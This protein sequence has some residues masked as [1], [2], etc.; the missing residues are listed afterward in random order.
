MNTD[1]SRI[2]TDFSWGTPKERSV[3]LRLL[4]VFIRGPAVRLGVQPI[5]SATQTAASGSDRIFSCH[6]AGPVSWTLLPVG[7]PRRPS[8]ACPPRRTRRSPPC[9]VPRRRRR[10]SARMALA[11]RYA[12]PPTAIR[13]TALCFRIASSPTGPRSD[14]PI[15]ADEARLGEHHLG[16]LVHA[17]GGGRT[18]GTDDLIAHRIDRTDVVDDA[19]GEVD[20]RRAVLRRSRRGRRSACAPRRDR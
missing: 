20:A 15:I 9:R 19:I 7:C 5:V 13:Y 6:S 17:R 14:L 8:P 12:A 4:S 11:T 2:H 18:S 3:R 1:N 10:A 16:E